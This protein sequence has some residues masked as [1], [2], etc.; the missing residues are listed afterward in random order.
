MKARN[1]AAR[2]SHQ[3]AATVEEPLDL[4]EVP[5]GLSDLSDLL[6]ERPRGHLARARG[7]AGKAEHLEAENVVHIRHSTRANEDR[8][9]AKQRILKGLGAGRSV[10]QAAAAAGVSRRVISLWRKADPAFDAA[11]RDVREDGLDACEDRVLK[12]GELDWRATLAY[13]RAHR[14]ERWGHACWKCALR[15]AEY[16]ERRATALPNPIEAAARL[17]EIAAKLEAEAA[18]VRWIDGLMQGEQSGGSA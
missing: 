12:A 13:L 9:R 2:T 14:P 15:Q 5:A 3:E 16:D 11:C 1:N 8:D 17:R 6:D 10:T 18:A 4:G 7:G